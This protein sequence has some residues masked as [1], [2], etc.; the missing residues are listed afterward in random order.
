MQLP[1][2]QN[3]MYGHDQVQYRYE[4]MAGYV[5]KLPTTG[6]NQMCQRDAETAHKQQK[7][8]NNHMVTMFDG[9]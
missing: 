7:G 4:L 6:T 9:C 8:T 1:E 5:P 2:N 3:G